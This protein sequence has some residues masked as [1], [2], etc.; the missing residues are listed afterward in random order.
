MT[1]RNLER[2]FRPASIAVIG[3]SPRRGSVGAIALR[4]LARGGFAGPIYPVNPNRLLIGRRKVWRSIDALPEAPDLAVVCTP[5]ETVPGVIEALGKRGTRAAVVLTTGLASRRD[6]TGATLRDAMLAAARPHL[7]RILGPGSVGLLVPGLGINASFAH[8][9]ARPGRLAFISQ[10]GSLVTAVLDRARS[11]RTGFSAFVSLGEGADV[12][13]GDLIDWFALDRDT[14]A[15]LLYVESIAAARKF[16]SATRAAARA[17]P[18]LIVKAGRVPDGAR[19]AA[20]HTGAIAG[21]DDVH[22][23]AIRRAGALRVTSTDDLFAAVEALTHA[24]VPLGDRLAIMGNGGGPAVMA[25]DAVVLDGGRLARLSPETIA[26][27]D[28]CLPDAP[29]RAN[30]VDIAGAAHADTSVAVA[31]ALLADPGADAL[32]F[33]HAPSALVQGV[34]IARAL[35]PVFRGAQRPVLACWLGAKAVHAARRIF[36]EAAIP[37]FDTPEQAVTAFMQRVRFRRNQALLTEVAP[38]AGVVADVVAARALVDAALDAGCDRLAGPDARR[39]LSLYGIPFADDAAPGD[40]TPPVALFVRTEVDPTFGPVIRFGEAESVTGHSTGTAV[41]LPPLNARLALD[42]ASRTAVARPDDLVR[43]LVGVS[44]L[45]A[46]LPEIVTLAI[47]PLLASARGVAARD[48]RVALARPG[49][50]GATAFAIRPYPRALEQTIDWQGERL[51]IRPVR[52][53]DT[54][55]H[56]AFFHALDPADVRMRAFATV[57]ELPPG[58]LARLTQ[59]DYDREMAFIATR[60]RPDGEPETLGVARASTDPDNLRAEFA[61]IVRSDL[62]GRGLGRRMLAILIDYCRSRGTRELVGETL[63]GNTGMIALAKA[64]GFSTR[65][66]AENATVFLALSLTT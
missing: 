65:F 24:P 56:L 45:L 18:V 53:E 12:D 33:I 16:M 27:L 55:Q 2:L 3:A 34:P 19:A 46:D 49:P 5:P 21:A 22:E 54:P 1:I 60:T 43:V 48:V 15:I 30:P 39:L 40:G 28:A 51:V 52:P 32:L 10:S 59:I 7:L 20:M 44:E 62:K 57:R 13:I 17:K 26:A 11:G 6:A 50:G 31:R 23:A 63:P 66:D 29:S 25:T 4:N 58:V 8:T 35:V 14:D 42:L 61:M 9:G 36:D 47:H 64:L 38:F 37:T 41:A